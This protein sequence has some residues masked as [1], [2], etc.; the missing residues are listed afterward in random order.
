M[1]LAKRMNRLGTETAFEVL[2]KARKLE[3][4]GADI[5]HLEI[6][7]PDFDTPAHIKEAA[8]AALDDNFTKYTR[9]IGIVELR[10]AICH[11]YSQDCNLA[12][13]PENVIVSAGGKQAL[14]NVAMAL[15]DPGDQV[16]V[17]LLGGRPL[18]TK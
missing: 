12:C 15:L 14:F 13:N 6:G 5:I 8:K 1:K 17:Q 16:I 7:E 4:A 2:M 18:W 9:N 10:E 11:R 3:A